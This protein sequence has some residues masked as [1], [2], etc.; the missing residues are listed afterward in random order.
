[1]KK[2][3]F[4]IVLGLSSLAYAQEFTDLYGD[5]LGQTPPGDIPVVFAPG[6]V[7]TIYMEHSAP[8]FSPD[9]NEV[10][11]RV[12]QGFVS[13][14]ADVTV[15]PKTMKRV[16]GR[17]TVPMDSPY[18]GE[19]FIS[20]DGN[21]LY[22]TRLLSD[23]KADGPYFVEKQGDSWSEPQNIGLVAHF[24]ELHSVYGLTVTRDGT[25]YFAGDTA[26]LGML[27][28]L[29]LYRAKLLNGEYTQLETL[30]PCI[31]LPG[32]WNYTPFI[33]P[34]E[35]YLI[36]SSNR[37]GS[38]DGYGDLYI[39]FHDI[40]KDTW[41]EPVNLGEPINTL[42]QESS[43]GLSPDGEYLFFTGPNAGNQADIFWVNA[44]LYLPDSNGPVL[45]RNQSIRFSTIQAA[46]HLAQPGD[47]IV[48][49]PGIYQENLTID[50]KDIVLR[51]T[52][53]N[54]PFYIGGTI[55]TGHSDNPVVALSNNSS[56]CQI[57]GLTI[58]A[59]SVG[60][61]GTTIQATVRN[62]RIMDNITH[63]VELFQE[64]NPHLKDC[65]IA[66]NGDTGIMMHPSKGRGKPPCAPVIENCIIVDNGKAA[67]DGGEPYIFDS[68]IQD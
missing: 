54:D 37:P 5:Y 12:A 46:I 22:F 16:E 53:P 21:R 47:E 50:G 20:P 56:A 38:L 28:D 41:S 55:I 9:G 60:I 57:A 29:V 33:A 24:P 30:P 52:D 3:L 65:L 13:V 7:S 34:D 66:C 39:S 59:G 11:W 58:R 1:M 43:P 61:S 31:N 15:M 36:F 10:F 64:S 8:T 62:C 26:G 6:I 18:G 63:G 14:P 23:S 32:S 19:P 51:S 17:W 42:G 68:I 49:E 4:L 67:I 48:I 27:K 44:R 2:S 35:S 25:L 45:N 40:N